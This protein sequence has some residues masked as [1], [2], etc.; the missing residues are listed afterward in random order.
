L[1]QL[2]FV[3]NAEKLAT[4]GKQDEEREKKTTTQYVL[5]TTTRKQT[6]TTKARKLFVLFFFSPLTY[7]TLFDVRLH[8]TPAGIFTR[9]FFI[10]FKYIGLS[11]IDKTVCVC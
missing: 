8:T 6:Q 9:F 5:D 11:V 3:D 10:Q 2:C 4:E 1:I 7:L